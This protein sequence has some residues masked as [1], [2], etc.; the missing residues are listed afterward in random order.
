MYRTRLSLRSRALSARLAAAGLCLCTLTASVAIAQ[1]CPTGQSGKGGFIVERGEQQKSQIFHAE[2]GIVRTITRYN[3]ATILETTQHEALFQLDRLD[4]GR[5]TKYEPQTDLKKLFPLKL[6]RKISAKFI[7]GSNGQQGTLS[8]E[9]AVKGADVLYVGP[10]KYSVLKIERSESRSAEPPRFVDTDY[11]S[12]E[13]KLVL[14]KE[15]RESNG[16]T[17]TIKYDR[18]YPLETLI[19]LGTSP[20]LRRS[21]PGRSSNSTISNA[22]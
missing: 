7:T 18:I 21:V 6:G 11:Y 3:G 5:R 1:D 22:C 4:N 20:L 2:D 9:F 12:P 10:C 16:G 15:Y 19:H 13:L 8:V 17:H 14:A